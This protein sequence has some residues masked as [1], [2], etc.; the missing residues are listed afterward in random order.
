MTGG[1]WALISCMAITIVLILF[2]VAAVWMSHEI[3]ISIKRR[4]E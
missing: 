1:E 2:V 3:N 4:D